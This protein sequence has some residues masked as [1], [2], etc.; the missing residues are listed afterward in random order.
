M[1]VNSPIHLSEA[2]EAAK[3]ERLIFNCMS[4][5]RLKDKEIEAIL[6]LVS[7]KTYKKGTLLLS[8]GEI[9]TKCYFNF[10]GGV[11]QY[12]LKDGEEK[13][14]CFYLE[15]QSITSNTSTA[16]K[17][18]AKHYLECIED[19]TLAVMTHEK[20]EALYRQFPRLESLC[21]VEMELRLG[22]YQEMLAN[23]MITTPEERYL[24]VLKYQPALLSRV[25]QYQLA[26]YLGVK[27]E[28]LSRIRKRILTK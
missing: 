6:D 13:T 5:S 14:T 7:I 23:Y 4:T 22:Q 15:N 25:P 3:A 18:P 8:E 9:S 17:I 2:N 24:N 20:E 27:P 28:S 21:R 11:R 1:T 10:K 19:T 26:S 12:Y 16:L